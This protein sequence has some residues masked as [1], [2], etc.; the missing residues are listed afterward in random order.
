MEI[1]SR[2]LQ[3]EK[4]LIQ[5]GIYP[6][7]NI[8]IGVPIVAQQERI[9]LGNMRLWVQSLASLCGLKIRCCCECGVGHRW[10]SDLVLLWPW[11]RLA[12]TA[13]IRPLAWGPLICHGYGLK[14]T[15]DKKKKNVSMLFMHG[16]IRARKKKYLSLLDLVFTTGRCLEKS[17][18][19]FSLEKED[20]NSVYFQIFHKVP[21]WIICRKKKWDSSLWWLN[22]YEVTRN[23]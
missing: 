21:T 3:T 10:G 17:S 18:V 15:K 9:W 2:V 13:L 20:W 23:Y 16:N 19:S 1:K 8:I 5:Q 4:V 22:V 7:K 11:R 6:V 12:A 14:N